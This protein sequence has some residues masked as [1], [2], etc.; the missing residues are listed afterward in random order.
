MALSA[1]LNN[2]MGV[3]QKTK[4]ASGA[5]ALARMLG[6]AAVDP[7]GDRIVVQADAIPPPKAVDPFSEFLTTL[8]G[9]KP[10]NGYQDNG[11]Q[12]GANF[13]RNI[14]G[15]GDAADFNTQR[16]NSMAGN[17]LASVRSAASR[18]ASMGEEYDTKPLDNTAAIV[19]PVYAQNRRTVVQGGIDDERKARFREAIANQD[20]ATAAQIDPTGTLAIQND[21]DARTAA[22][23]ATKNAT[24]LRILDGLKNTVGGKKDFAGAV[25]A[26][27]QA[28][29]NIFDQQTLDMVAQGGYDAAA[30][31]LGKGPAKPNTV[32]DSATDT[33]K[34][35]ADDGSVIDTGVAR[36][37]TD[38]AYKMSMAGAANT[39][40][41]AAGGGSA[42]GS[43]FADPTVI[44]AQINT[45]R[46][47]IIA[48]ARNGTFVDNATQGGATR[49][50]ASMA[51]SGA[52]QDL[53]FGVGKAV[54]QFFSPEQQNIRDQVDQTAN[55]IAQSI[56]A[57]PGMGAA[58]L[59]DTP[60]EV[61]RIMKII[62]DGTSDVSVM[63]NAVD[64]LEQIFAKSMKIAQEQVA[65]GG[66]TAAVA[67]PT[68]SGTVIR[69]DAEGNRIK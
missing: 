50:G 63:M 34:V 29:P 15:G 30:R 68:P 33:I 4:S 61:D 18:A 7:A 57:L 26:F 20:Y 65:A 1:I 32:L 48:G 31:A 35:L 19:D 37:K 23:T 52:M 41:N 17:D 21:T 58:K 51:N 46:K 6:G 8:I 16:Q 2:L 14:L 69:Y 10:D 55:G 66:T 59:F 43:G 49:A 45:L 12:G 64:Q 54:Q 9:G 42:D 24:Q 60:K 25:A 36:N 13:I 53:P 28:N 67:S 5:D 22:T 56:R 40:A 27:S 62:N 11:V 44:A 47:N 3:A 39:R 38:D